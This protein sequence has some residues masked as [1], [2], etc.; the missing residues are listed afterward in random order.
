MGDTY[1]SGGPE[2]HLPT[3]EDLRFEA[4]GAL[5]DVED[6]LRSDWRAGHGPTRAQAD[7]VSDARRHIA[8]A[9]EA[10]NRAAP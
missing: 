9:K 6:V 10:L 5:G 8:A 7:A 2:A 3:F 1:R 4:Y